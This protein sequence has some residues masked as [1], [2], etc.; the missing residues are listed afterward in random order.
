MNLLLSTYDV[1]SL[2]TTWQLETRN[3]GN[4]RA[5][6]YYFLFCFVDE[7]FSAPGFVPDGQI[8]QISSPTCFF[9]S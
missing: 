2:E 3:H 4:H 6:G 7:K 1:T 5:V 8:S 9:T